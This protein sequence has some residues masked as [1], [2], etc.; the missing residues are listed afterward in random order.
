[1]KSKNSSLYSKWCDVMRY[2]NKTGA[3]S[4]CPGDHQRL[5]MAALSASGAQHKFNL[6]F[7]YT[8]QSRRRSRPSGLSVC[9]HWVCIGSDVREIIEMAWHIDKLT[10]EKKT[11]SLYCY[12]SWDMTMTGNVH[13]VL[14]T[15]NLLGLCI[16]M[17]L[18]KGRIES[19]ALT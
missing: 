4:P 18:E 16:C 6:R 1:M 8:N 13:D 3:H 2:W 10:V 12:S 19:P 5:D 9:A 14:F 15:L 7:L 11:A 17:R